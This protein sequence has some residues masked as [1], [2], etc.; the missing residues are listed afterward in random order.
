MPRP[1][2]LRWILFGTHL[3]RSPGWKERPND[4]MKRITYEKMN[5]YKN[6]WVMEGNY[7]SVLGGTDCFAAATD[8]ICT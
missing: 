8:V 1:C 6:G 2:R 5:E 7:L 4:D 3:Q